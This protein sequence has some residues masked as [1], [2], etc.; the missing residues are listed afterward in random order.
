MSRYSM[1]LSNPTPIGDLSRYLLWPCEEVL[2][3]KCKQVMR[4]NAYNIDMSEDRLRP[5][6][7]P[8]KGRHNLGVPLEFEVRT[9]KGHGVF[10]IYRHW[11]WYWEMSWFLDDAQGRHFIPPK[12]RDEWVRDLI[13]GAKRAKI[14]TPHPEEK[15]FPKQNAAHTLTDPDTPF[16]MEF[17]NK[18]RWDRMS[19]GQKFM[20]SYWEANWRGK[21]FL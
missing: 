7:V 18:P 9:T 20:Y 6:H 11:D 12:L 15:P 16:F 4:R 17:I 2:W 21:K 13:D 19:E 8:L 3:V 5:K 1:V 10:F 14:Y